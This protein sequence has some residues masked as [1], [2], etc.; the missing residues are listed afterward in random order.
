MWRSVTV[1]KPNFGIIPMR[2]VFYRKYMHIC[3]CAWMIWLLYETEHVVWVMLCIWWACGRIC[4]CIDVKIE[5]KVYKYFNLGT[6]LGLPSDVLKLLWSSLR[7]Q[8]PQN[9]FCVAYSMCEWSSICLLYIF[10]GCVLLQ[11]ENIL[12]CHISCAAAELS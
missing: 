4:K 10:E 5:W 2:G 1:W 6:L 9:P 3:S 7:L 11:I 12:H 8:S